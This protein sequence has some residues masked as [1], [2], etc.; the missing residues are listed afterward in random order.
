M[1]AFAGPHFCPPFLF[2][3]LSNKDTPHPSPHNHHWPKTR[4]IWQFYGQKSSPDFIILI[5]IAEQTKQN[6]FFPN[7]V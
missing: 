3:G 2:A 5:T 6:F 4:A 1:A 7:F